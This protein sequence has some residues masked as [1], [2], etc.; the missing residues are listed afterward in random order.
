MQFF[1]SSRRRHTRSYGDWSSDVCSSDL[2]NGSTFLFVDP[3]G[4]KGL[5]LQLVN[6]VIKDWGCDCVFFFNYNRISMGQI[7]R[8]SC[9]EREYR[10]EGIRLWQR[11]EELKWRSLG[12]HEDA[13]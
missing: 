1:F 2:P 13:A 8:A 7:G 6:S 11:E 10:R 5:S 3:F 4:Y 9:R 12:G